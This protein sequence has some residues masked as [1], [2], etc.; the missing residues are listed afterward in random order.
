MATLR[1]PEGFLP[2]ARTSDA[3]AAMLQ[4]STKGRNSFN[5]A[6]IRR[7][8]RL[9]RAEGARGFQREQSTC[10]DPMVVSTQP[11]AR[12]VRARV[13]RWEWPCQIRAAPLRHRVA[14]AAS[15]DGDG[16]SDGS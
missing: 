6:S 11:A 4:A 13:Q 8:A 1:T 12:T 15:L 7:M 10:L 9:F 2:S 16:R 3:R 5:A 14:P